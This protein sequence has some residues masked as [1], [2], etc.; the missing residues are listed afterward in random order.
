MKRIGLFLN[1]P[2][3]DGGT[4]QY[5]QVI[6]E[7]ITALDKNKYK[8]IVVYTNDLWE[9][10]LAQYDNICAVFICKTYYSRKMWYLA[11]KIGLSI[12]LWR[13]YGAY[14]DPFANKIIKLQCDL[15]IFPSQDSFSYLLPVPA[16]STI[17]DLM[18]RYEKFP[19]VLDN[20]EFE[21]RELH[22]YNMCKWVKGILVDS[23]IGRQQVAQCYD[24]NL[25][26]VF[27]L[28]FIAPK[29][30]YD[31]N[32]S[33]DSE[34]VEK[35]NLPNKYIFY[36]A[37]FWKHKN[38]ENLIKSIHKVKSQI[39]D[40]QLVLVGSKKNGYESAQDL[41]KSLNLESNIHFLGYVP[42]NDMPVLYSKARAMIMPTFFG[43][44]NIPPLEG[45]ASGCPVAISN[46]YGMPEQVKDAALLFNPDS[47][48]EISEIIIRLWTD[49]SLCFELI[50]RGFARDKEWGQP[51]FNKRLEEIIETIL[52][53]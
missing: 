41:V 44:T 46:R 42:D 11:R 23:E 49:D 43:P 30:I 29:Y 47:I 34:I 39:S 21:H 6:L 10:Y 31:Y 28:P 40:I 8:I 5:N 14:I 37:Q 17:H 9:R 33:N 7:A 48:E 45:F 25:D 15:W 36:P 51:E 16:L 13:R 20:G 24:K 38:H 18:H 50:Q 27:V 35:Y 53:E 19:E 12:D 4:Y 2:P 52:S 22:Y 3:H 1:S 26:N 32:N